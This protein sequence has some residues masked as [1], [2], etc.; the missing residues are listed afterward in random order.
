MSQLY[1]YKWYNIAKFDPTALIQL[2]SNILCWWY[3][4]TICNAYVIASSTE[5]AYESIK[6]VWPTI[7]LY[8]VYSVEEADFI[9]TPD[10]LQ[11]PEFLEKRIKDYIGLIH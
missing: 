1:L 11:L 6:L 5:S 9:N 10:N 8:D 7:T 4:N 2:E 3:D